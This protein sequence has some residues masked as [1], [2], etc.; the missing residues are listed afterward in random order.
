MNSTSTLCSVDGRR[1]PQELYIKFFV[2]HLTTLG[3]FFH[4]ARRRDGKYLGWTPILFIIAPMNLVFRYV[5][6]LVVIFG[7]Y[8]CNVVY[9]Y[10][11]H[12]NNPVALDTLTTPL[13]WL[14][15]KAPQEPEYTILTSDPIL[16]LTNRNT[17]A[18]SLAKKIGKAFA[19]GI[20]LT[21]CSGAIFLYHRRLQRDA[22]TKVDQRVFELACGGLIVG[23]LTL[24]LSFKIPIFSETVPEGSGKTGM[25]RFA[26]FCRDSCSKPLFAFAFKGGGEAHWARFFKNAIISL[27]VYAISFDSLFYSFSSDMIQAV[28][29]GF[30]DDPEGAYIKAASI[31][32]LC[33]FAGFFLVKLS[34]AVKAETRSEPQV[35]WLIYSILVLLFTLL[36]I[37]FII[38]VLYA[39]FFYVAAWPLAFDEISKLTVL[40]SDVA[41]PLLWSDPMSQWVWWLA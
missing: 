11:R 5:I 12:K 16:P 15:G 17:K 18:E 19:V 3:F 20:F 26:L 22:V 36:L 32:I 6:A 21:Q 34:H 33:S 4:L 10:I 27:I 2:V 24:G 30:R 28:V 25:D 13:S 1:T 7:F 40:P 9:S 39:L 29:D 41:C 37:C 31:V 14:L 35:E 38:G 23:L 8:C